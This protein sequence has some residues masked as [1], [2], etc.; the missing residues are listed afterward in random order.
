MGMLCRSDR[1]LGLVKSAE[2]EALRSSSLEP[3]LLDS[4]SVEQLPVV[5]EHF[6]GCQCPSGELSLHNDL[7]ARHSGPGLLSDTNRA[8]VADASKPKLD[9]VT[10]CM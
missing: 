4:S 2:P 6:S 1:G 5:A 3:V 8:S 10:Y 7:G 9:R